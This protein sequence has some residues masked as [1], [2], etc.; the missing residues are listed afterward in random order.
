[1]ICIYYLFYS[2]L[3]LMCKPLTTLAYDRPSCIYIVAQL[4]YQS[5]IEMSVHTK[6]T[7]EFAKYSHKEQFELMYGVDT[8]LNLR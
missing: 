6:E 3:R 5:A 2:S 7:R 1:M 8:L 4:G